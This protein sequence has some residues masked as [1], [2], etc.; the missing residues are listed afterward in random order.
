MIK[1]ITTNGQTQ[2]GISEFVIDSPEDLNEMPLKC[3]MGSTAIC[4]ETGA[5]YM[6]NSNGEWKEI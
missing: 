1:M 6:K 5:V 4:I 2:Y 3:G